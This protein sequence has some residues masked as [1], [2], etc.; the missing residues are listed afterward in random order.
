[1]K[2]SVKFYGGKKAVDEIFKIEAE[3]FGLETEAKALNENT[4]PEIE[5]PKPKLTLQDFRKFWKFFSFILL[6][7]LRMILLVQPAARNGFLITLLLFGAQQLSGFNTLINY[8]A[9][10]FVESGSN[11][12]IL[13]SSMIIGLVQLL[14]TVVT[15]VVI[16]KFGGKVC[17]FYSFSLC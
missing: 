1:M 5:A 15:I 2:K 12:S 3:T 16:K 10:V 17:Q 13:D 8:T 14:A 6:K 7:L 9:S 11:L 4:E